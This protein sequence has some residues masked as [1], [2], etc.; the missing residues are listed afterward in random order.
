MADQQAASSLVE[1]GLGECER[2]V[3]AK[4]RAPEHDDQAA[5]PPAV[6]IAACRECLAAPKYPPTGGPRRLVCLSEREPT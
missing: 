1:V 4:A 3:D 5:H 2:L 6:T